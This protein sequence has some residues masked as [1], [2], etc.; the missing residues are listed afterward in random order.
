MLLF[1]G[2]TL[3]ALP[4]WLRL[5][6]HRDKAHVVITGACWWMF[7]SI[8]L[9]TIQPEWPRW[10]LYVTVPMVGVGYAVVDLMPWSR[11]RAPE[12]PRLGPGKPSARTSRRR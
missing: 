11:P 1:L 10:V 4:L 3:A 12:I 2:S 6:L 5:A 9:L 8:G 7:F